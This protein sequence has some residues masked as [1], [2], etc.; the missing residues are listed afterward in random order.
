VSRVRVGR[1]N[2]LGFGGGI[3]EVR[4]MCG[5]KPGDCGKLGEAGNVVDVNCENAGYG[6]YE[7]GGISQSESPSSFCVVGIVGGGRKGSARSVGRI[8]GM[9]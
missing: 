2:S 4:V 6:L 7:S 1:S 9:D 3:D 8:P 5:W